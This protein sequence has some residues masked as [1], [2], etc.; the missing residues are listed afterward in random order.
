M[1]ITLKAKSSSGDPY[2]VDFIFEKG[3]LSVHCTCRAGMMR[4]A[5]KHRLSLLKGDKKMLADPS[6]AN[7]LATVVEWANQV[8]FSNLLQQLDA[9]EAELSRL[10]REVKKAKKRLEESMTHGLNR[11]S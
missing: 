6:Q 4:T 3:V 8:G 1:K 10:Q 11:S 9:A 2:D 5:C 7:Q